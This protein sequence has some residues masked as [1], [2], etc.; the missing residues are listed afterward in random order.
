MSQNIIR[1][2]TTSIFLVSTAF[3]ADKATSE[4]TSTARKNALSYKTAE[5]GFIQLSPGLGGYQLILA[6]GD[7]R[8]WINLKHT[9][10][11][12]DLYGESMSQAGGQFPNKAND[13]VEWR[14]H[15][16]AKGF[17]PYAVI[18]RINS[19][20]PGNNKT[21]SRLLVIKLD[22]AN[23]KVIGHTQG[24]NEDAQAKAMADAS[25]TNLA[26]PRAGDAN[27]NAAVDLKTFLRS[28]PKTYGWQ[29][30]DPKD[31]IL[32]D[33]F[34]NGD[35]GI[36]G[37]DGEATMWEGKWSLKGDQLTLTNDSLKTKKTVTAKING[38]EILLDN[39]RHKRYK[40]E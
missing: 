20:D 5:G 37:P 17:Q 35:L 39:V 33:F 21:I 40:P 30:V 11:E 31:F 26:P 4:Y 24:A 36:Q 15:N 12:V 34:P 13:V 22:G 9:G 2:F 14:G 32:Y 28:T 10:G 29:P 16:T 8:S 19:T 38:A 1:I 6:A 27:K 3:A 23:S 18:Y 7:D 25:R